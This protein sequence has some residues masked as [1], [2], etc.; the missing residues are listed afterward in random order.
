MSIFDGQDHEMEIDTVG[1]LVLTVTAVLVVGM[2]LGALYF[3]ANPT[4]DEQIRY[5]FAATE[6]V[7]AGGTVQFSR[8]Q[9]Q[10]MNKVYR[11]KREE[12]G[13]CLEIDGEQ[14]VDLAHP[15]N[16]KHNDGGSI[17]FYCDRRSTNG[18]LHTHPGLFAVPEL[19]ET[20]RQNLLNSSLAV[21][22]V[23]SEAVPGQYNVNPPSL[24][25]FNR[26]LERMQIVIVDG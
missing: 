4:L 23:L 3:A 21:S 14:V 15:P 16:I 2:F 7:Q 12:Y 25:C 9:I 8:Q 11:D 20:D 13:W 5:T 10:E 26:D 18:I 6:S 17:E 19:S 1:E 22:C 24:N